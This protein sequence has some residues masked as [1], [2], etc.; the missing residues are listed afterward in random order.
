[1]NICATSVKLNPAVHNKSLFIC[2]GLKCPGLG[3]MGGHIDRLISS[4]CSSEDF[5][6]SAG[7]L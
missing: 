7:A 2:I 6:L 5:P 3:W 4:L 1:M